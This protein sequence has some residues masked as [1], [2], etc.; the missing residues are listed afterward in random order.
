M[1]GSNAPSDFFADIFEDYDW[2]SSGL[3]EEP[4]NSLDQ[5]ELAWAEQG[6]EFF[7]IIPTAAVVTLG[8]L[9]FVNSAEE[10]D[11]SASDNLW[12]GFTA[13]VDSASGWQL[14]E[15]IN[16]LDETADLAPDDLMNSFVKAEDPELV[17]KLM[18]KLIYQWFP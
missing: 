13:S 18:R 8:E 14:Q 9:E 2:T 11:N 1:G 16:S 4:S 7:G 6:N 3:L 17:G 12:E 15:S 5:A 10:T